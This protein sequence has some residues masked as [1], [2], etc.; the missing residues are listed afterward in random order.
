MCTHGC[1]PAHTPSNHAGSQP[2]MYEVPYTQKPKTAVPEPEH[3]R[4]SG[5]RAN[6][7]LIILKEVTIVGY[8]LFRIMTQSQRLMALR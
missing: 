8:S 2:V 5:S 7:E 1:I 3:N 4:C 6:D